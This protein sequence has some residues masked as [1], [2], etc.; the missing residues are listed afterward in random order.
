MNSH[1]LERMASEKNLD[2]MRSVEFFIAMCIFF[3]VVGLAFIAV[4]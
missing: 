4:A 3:C 2:M 1:L